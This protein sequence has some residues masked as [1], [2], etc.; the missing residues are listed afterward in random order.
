MRDRVAMEAGEVA[1]S[2]RGLGVSMGDAEVVAGVDLELRAGCMTALVG[3]SGCGK[4]VTAAALGGLLPRGMRV[5]S[6][7]WGAPDG[8]GGLREVRA[9]AGGLAYV[10]QDPGVSLNPVLT[11]GT[12]VGEALGLAG[13]G[14]RG[15]AAEILRLLRETGLEDAERTAR[16]YPHELSGGMQQR[17]MTAMAL[18]LRPSVLVADEPTTALD[19]T[20]QA[21]ILRLLKDLQDKERLATLLIT[22]NLGVVAE[23]ADEVAVMYAGRL[24]ETGPVAEVLRHPAHPYV[25]ALLRALPRL[26]SADGA[27][28]ELPGRVPPPGK[29]P[30]GCR[31]A[32]RCAMGAAECRAAEPEWREVGPGHRVACGN[33]AG[34]GVC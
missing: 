4:S 29:R 31:F 19:V 14:R 33:G 2:V 34:R 27:L 30:P 16:S 24:V 21:K 6:G 1:L 11:V 15:R 28:E 5:T 7:V 13:W 9:G 25:K 32:A 23:V 3:E 26:D 8:K 18:A 10:F 22:H 12:Q 17:V 20:V